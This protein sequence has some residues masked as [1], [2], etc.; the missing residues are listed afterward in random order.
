M[1]SRYFIIWLFIII[2]QQVGYSEKIPVKWGRV[3]ED[4]FI[5]VGQENFKDASAVVICDYGRIT[6]SNRTFYYRYKRLKINNPE[7]L[8]YAKIEIPYIYR[9]NYDVFIDLKVNLYI[10]ENGKIKKIKYRYNDFKDLTIDEDRKIKYFK[11]PEATS[12]CIIEYIYEIAS[13]DFVKLRDWYFQSEIP[14][15]WSGIEINVP[16]PITYI[17]SIKKYEYLDDVEILKF[18]NKLEWLKNTNPIKA[19]VILSKNNYVLYESPSGNYRVYILSNQ[20]K[21]IYMKNLSGISHV[22]GF[23]S[24]KDYYPRI[25][26]DLFE[27]NGHIPYRYRSLLYTTYND[28]F[29][30]SWKE[31]FYSY[32]Y[33]NFVK[34]FL[35]TWEEFNRDLIESKFF[36][37]YFNKYF[38]YKS[39]IN[40]AFGNNDNISDKYKVILLYKYLTN[41]INW[42]GNFKMYPYKDPDKLIIDGYGHSGDLN[43]IFI[44][45]LRK[46]NIDVYPVLIRTNNL[47]LP[48][49]A[50]PVHGQFNHVI[51]YVELDEGT[52]LVDLTNP[53]R[54]WNELPDYDLNTFGWKVDEKDYGWVDIK[55]Y[56]K[57]SDKDYFLMVL[58]NKKNE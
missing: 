2:A 58:A 13:L 10:L 57:K 32:S 17:V 47:G 16:Y 53:Q 12:N 15:L 7:G 14:V 4:D 48:E 23:I 21:L 24:I 19:R 30:Y 8:K 49:K 51:A 54:K 36:G 34:Y 42:T 45:L 33:R 1:K 39:I 27:V 9:Y 11:I 43:M 50:F 20:S 52:Y 22:E 5:S 56:T 25:S 55:Q 31:F 37:G 40:E 38:D 41:K 28:Y 18:S 6:F 35:K 3:K 26:F 46:L 44:Y 29:F